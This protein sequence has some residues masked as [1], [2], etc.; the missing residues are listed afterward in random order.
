MPTEALTP[1]NRLIE[2]YIEMAEKLK[3]RPS[4]PSD[5]FGHAIDTGE[6]VTLLDEAR[7]FAKDFLEEER[8][9]KF[10][11]G[12]SDFRALDLFVYSIHLA[13]AIAGCQYDLAER[14]LRHMLPTLQLRRR[15]N[16]LLTIDE[17]QKL[18]SEGQWPYPKQQRNS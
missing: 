9:D 10:W 14:L 13:R 15:N 2:I 11:I 17:I 8:T 7:A 16:V 6:P 12:C 3:Y 4:A 18:V 1:F 5:G